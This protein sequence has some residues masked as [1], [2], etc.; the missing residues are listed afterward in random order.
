MVWL[1]LLGL[2][3]WVALVEGLPPAG[4]LVGCAAQVA[5]ASRKASNA[6]YKCVLGL[7]ILGRRFCAGA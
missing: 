5:T 1:G 3:V 4:G 7:V 6:R 2:T